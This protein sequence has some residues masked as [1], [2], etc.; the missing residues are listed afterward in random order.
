MP[1]IPVELFATSGSVVDLA[2]K[3][4]WVAGERGMV[5]SA[6]VRRLAR[7]GAILLS[8]GRA[9]LDPRSRRKRRRGLPQTGRSSSLSPRQGSV[10]S[11][12]IRPT[13][14]NFSTTI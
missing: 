3:R 13:Q 5:G 1:P 2:G 14:V 8:V 10:A 4:V 11:W 7:E 6:L 12:Q 9:A